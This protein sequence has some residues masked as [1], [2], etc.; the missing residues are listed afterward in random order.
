MDQ[1]HRSEDD[2]AW[3]DW[4]V[5]SESS[6]DTDSDGWID[7]SSESSDDVHIDDDDKSEASG[8]ESTTNVTTDK[9]DNDFDPSSMLVTSQ[10]W[11]IHFF[12]S[13]E[14]ESISFLGMVQILTP[15]DFKLLADLRE[16]AEKAPVSGRG[17]KRKLVSEQQQNDQPITAEDIMGPRKRT[18]DDY[19]AR[20]SSIAQGREGREKYSAPRRKSRST[21]KGSTN[22]EKARNKPLMMVM[23]GNIRRRKKKN[24][25]RRRS[26]KSKKSVK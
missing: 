13:G 11:P 22:K 5:A 6:V 7:V 12:R 20:L 24:G 8:D 21:S 18:K 2:I 26:G 19:A 1:V 9:L 3:Q 25:V 14:P 16:Q 23:S 4:E 15:A 10:V 17:A